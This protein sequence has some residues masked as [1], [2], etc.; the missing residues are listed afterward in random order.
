MIQIN[1]P[2]KFFTLLLILCLGNSFSLNAQ[3][4]TD[5]YCT[6]TQG[7][8]GNPN[9]IQYGETTIQI[10]ENALSDGN[11]QNNPITLGVPGRSLTINRSAAACVIEWLPG[12]GASKKLPSGDLNVDGNCNAGALPI[13]KGR[14]KNNLITQAITL[15]LNMRYDDR[16]YYLTLE[17]ACIS[18][19]NAIYTKLG[20]NATIGDLMEYTNEALGG[21]ISGNLGYLTSAIGAVNDHFD[22]CQAACGIVTPPGGGGGGLMFRQTL[23]TTE[24]FVFPNPAKDFISINVEN[25]IGE[26]VTIQIYNRLG[27][28][29][30]EQQINQLA[31][32][33]IR[34]DL[35]NFSLGMHVLSIRSNTQQANQKFIVF[36]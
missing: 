15:A 11:G 14:I 26:D 9:G 21:N 20:D 3:A 19:S 29:Q 8:Y 16:L 2:T 5:N 23:A 24:I 28:L 7:Y 22:E 25:F 35:N 18:S 30:K 33:M 4:G 31:E 36:K 27:M 13:R 34:V 12:G 6:F 1:M 32:G 10:I 17:N